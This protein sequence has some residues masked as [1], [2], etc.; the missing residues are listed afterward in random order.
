MLARVFSLASSSGGRQLVHRLQHVTFSVSAASAAPRALSVAEAISVA[1]ALTKF[2]LRR[3]GD[4]P[5][6]SLTSVRSSLR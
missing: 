4:A 6:K 2:N 1:K 5:V 3:A